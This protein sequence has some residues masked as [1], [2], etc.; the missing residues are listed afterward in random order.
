L[1]SCALPVTYFASPLSSLC[2]PFFPRRPQPNTG[3]RVLDNVLA[4]EFYPLSTVHFQPSSIFSFFNSS[5]CSP[6]LDSTKRLF[7]RVGSRPTFRPF[8]SS[9]GAWTFT[10]SVFS[11]PTRHPPP[12]SFRTRSG[13]DFAFSCFSCSL[14]YENTPEFAFPFGC[15]ER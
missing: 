6:H 15:P 13:S 5:T 14:R 8:L 7:Q 12:F 9:I 4:F 10:P 11:I 1:C 3:L 2:V